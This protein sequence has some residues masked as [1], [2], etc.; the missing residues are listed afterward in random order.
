MVYGLLPI[1]SLA[2]GIF[3]SSLLGLKEIIFSSVF[4]SLMSPDHSQPR[5]LTASQE[6][7]HPQNS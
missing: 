1:P 6:Y 7:R 2:L 5:A 3:D 4:Q